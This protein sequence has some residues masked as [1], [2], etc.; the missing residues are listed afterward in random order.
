MLPHQIF[1]SS[2]AMEPD[3]RLAGSRLP[4]R[5]CLILFQILTCQLSHMN[6]TADFT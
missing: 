1:V 3:T 5:F 6:P 2:D 4:I